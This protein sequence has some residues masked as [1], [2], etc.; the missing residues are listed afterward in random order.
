MSR[1]RFPR[2]R[3]KKGG[4]KKKGKKKVNDYRKVSIIGSG[5]GGKKQSNKKTKKE[6]NS[7]YAN[8]IRASI[9][10]SSSVDHKLK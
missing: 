5:E 8:G 7:R 4:E 1:V 3:K 2:K 9:E 6:T 10:F